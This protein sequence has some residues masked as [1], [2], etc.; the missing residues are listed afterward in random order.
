MAGH[1][2]ITTTAIYDQGA[3]HFRDA[4]E[5]LEMAQG[6]LPEKRGG[7]YRKLKRKFRF[8]IISHAKTTLKNQKTLA[9]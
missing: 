3:E 6:L 5:A 7:V 8:N 9:S 4:T 2:Q 1:A